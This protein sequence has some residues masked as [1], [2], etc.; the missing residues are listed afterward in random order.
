L[1]EPR[2][3][4]SSS[5]SALRGLPV[6]EKTT[7]LGGGGKSE[8]SHPTLRE[9]GVVLWT[10]ATFRH[11]LFYY[12][13]V[14]LFAGAAGQ[15][16]AAFFMRSYGLKS[17]ALGTWLGVVS[18]LG[19]MLGMYSGGAWASRYAANNE[20]LQFRVAVVVYPLFAVAC[21]SVY[22]APN[23]Y[24]AFGFMAL[25]AIVG[26]SISAPVLAAIQTVVQPRMRAV[27]MA[28]ILLFT[29]LIGSGLGPLITGLLSDAFRPFFGEESLRYALLALCPA[30]LWPAWHLWQAS[31]S[32]TRD[33]VAVAQV[34]D[35]FVQVSVVVN[36]SSNGSL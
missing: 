16:Q 24:L 19:G 7:G 29:S 31:R 15:W 30:C 12:S 1:K 5:T 9:V 13:L 28:L 8:V 3:G 27:S 2:Q 25:A 21:T 26:N 14:A 11:L 36:A 22:L 32:V 20:R 33:L 17:G 18:G 10:T 6:L 23:Y 35:P 4:K 34:P